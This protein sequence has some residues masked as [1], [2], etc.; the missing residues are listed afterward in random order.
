[1]HFADANGNV[2]QDFAGAVTDGVVQGGAGKDTLE[3]G[4]SAATGTISGVGT[5]FTG[6]D[7]LMV[8]AAAHWSMIGANRLRATV[9]IDL[10][11]GGS[12]GVTGTLTAPADLSVTGAGTLAA[13]DGRIEV[14]TAGAASANQ[15]RVDAGHTLSGSG[16]LSATTVVVAKL[17]LV[18]ASDGILTLNGNVAGGG[19]LAAGGG[20]LVLIGANNA[21]ATV[22]NS[23]TIGLGGTLT[24]TGSVDPAGGGLF[25]L[26][27]NSLLEVAANTGTGEMSFSG[28]SGELVVD[29]VGLFGTNVGADFYTGPL[30]AGFGGSHETIDLKDLGLGGLTSNFVSFGAGAGRLQ[31]ASGTTKATLLF[32]SLQGGNTFHFA[33]DG[34]GH[35]LVTHH[36]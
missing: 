30:L 27:N 8:D 28:T 18:E 32:H 11:N 20:K 9:T 26:N 34:T 13:S 12:L 19:T 29:H 2:F 35:V 33:D 16:V 21:I 6:F 3:L 36:S 5:Q 17:A 15:I 25:I 7:S 31:L 14:G 4:F 22:A 10:E 24:V 1:V 23:S